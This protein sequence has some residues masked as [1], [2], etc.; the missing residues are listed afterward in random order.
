M[1]SPRRSPRRH[2]RDAFETLLSRVYLGITGVVLAAAP[3]IALLVQGQGA[4]QWPIW[5]GCILLALLLLGIA[6]LGISLRGE[7]RSV[8]RWVGV[9]MITEVSLTFVVL[10]VPIALLLL[11]SRRRRVPSPRIE[12][13]R[14]RPRR[15][16]LWAGAPAPGART[17]APSW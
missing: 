16:P 2:R 17:A 12:P 10:A 15:M 8:E 4:T 5:V 7:A 1:R 3:P 6:L 14:I 13:H 11:W 9:S